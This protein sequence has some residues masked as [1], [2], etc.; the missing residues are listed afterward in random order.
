[1]KHHYNVYRGPLP[2]CRTIT[3]S[4]PSC[5]ALPIRKEQRT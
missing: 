4:L 3:L 1:M 5:A 2:F